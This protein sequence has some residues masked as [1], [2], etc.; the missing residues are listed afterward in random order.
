MSNQLATVSVQRAYDGSGI[1]F[2]L[3]QACGWG[4]LLNLGYSRPWDWFIYPFRADIAQERLVRRSIDLLKVEANQRVLD[5][6][7]GRGKSSFLLAMQHPTATI[8]GMDKLTTHVEIAK[9]QYGNT[10]NLEYQAGDAEALPF[11]D[12]SFARVHCLEAAFHFDRQRFLQEVYRVLKPGGRVVIVDFMWKDANS[13]RLLD[14][15]DGKIV[16]DIWQF[17]DLWTVAEYLEAADQLGLRKTE[18]I[19]WSEPVTGMSYKRM[20]SLVKA[21]LNPAQLKKFC[22]LH[23]PLR[24]FSAD[25]WEIL[26]RY[27]AAHEPL[28]QAAYYMALALEKD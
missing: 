7:C 26:R 2:Q 6:A 11:P 20:Q 23:P 18:L 10:R 12:Q 25:D 17:V 16:Q 14:T 28:R 1:Y 13:R 15:P 5:V 19:D 4:E 27:S 9:L 21:S 3:L 24:H 8:V 22:Q